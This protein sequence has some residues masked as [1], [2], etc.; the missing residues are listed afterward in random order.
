MSRRRGAKPRNVDEAGDARRPSGAASPG[1]AGRPSGGSVRGSGSGAPTAVSRGAR[2]ARTTRPRARLTRGVGEKILRHVEAWVGDGAWQDS[3]NVLR[4]RSR[5]G[6]AG[7]RINTAQRA[8]GPE[9]QFALRLAERRAAPGSPEAGGVIGRDGASFG[10][11]YVPIIESF[12]RPLRGMRALAGRRERGRGK[13]CCAESCDTA[14]Q[15]S[16]VD[17]PRLHRCSELRL[18]GHVRCACQPGCSRGRRRRRPDAVCRGGGCAGR[19]S[20]ELLPVCYP[21]RSSRRLLCCCSSSL[22]PP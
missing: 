18:R 5:C 2:R 9:R 20:A 15:S 1:A 17:A 22:P 11:A 12:G 16:D 6:T 4:T 19:P 8:H 21:R 3:Q 13:A 14:A 7:Q 10:L